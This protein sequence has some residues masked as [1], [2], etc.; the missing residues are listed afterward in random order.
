MVFILMIKLVQVKISI[1]EWE[2]HFV[3][4]LWKFTMQ[5]LYKHLKDVDDST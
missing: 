5:I 4:S 3:F 2:I 1:R